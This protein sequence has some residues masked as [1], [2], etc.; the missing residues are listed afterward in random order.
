[1]QAKGRAFKATIEYVSGKFGCDK[2]HAFFAGHPQ[3]SCIADFH[4]L[5]W[6]DL[7]YYL[8]FSEAID[9]HFGF[10]DASL[11]V[12]IGEY[13]AKHAFETS[14][15]LFRDLSV[16]SAI[17]NAEAVFFSFYSAGTVEIKYL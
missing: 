9:R 10:G 17:S 1:M 16:E 14:H 5:N 3:Y 2:L 4:D 11:L 6:Y 15:R 13:A 7:D 12:E 8:G